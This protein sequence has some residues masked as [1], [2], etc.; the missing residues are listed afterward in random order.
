M[1]R[2]F[3]IAA[4]SLFV[5]SVHGAGSPESWIWGDSYRGNFESDFDENTKSWQ[6]IQAQLPPYPKAENLIAFVVSSATS[7]KYFVDLPSVSTGQDGAV[8]YTVV[9]KSPAGAETVSFEG[10]RCDIGLSKLYAFGRSDGKGGGEWSRNRYAKWDVIKDRQ[11]TS[12]QREL[13]YHYFCTVEGAANLKAIQRLLK[14]GG[15]YD[16]EAGGLFSP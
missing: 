1:R 3:A 8:R 7:N 16:R 12:Y 6:E 9:V 10:M 13:F 14:S 11:Q 15:L 5:A 4:A 2:I